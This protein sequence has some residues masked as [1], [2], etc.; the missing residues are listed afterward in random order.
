MIRIEDDEVIGIIHKIRLSD[1]KNTELVEDLLN[2]INGRKLMLKYNI[3]DQERVIFL[4]KS[5]AWK[6]RSYFINNSY[7]F[8]NHKQA[9]YMNDVFFSNVCDFSLYL[10]P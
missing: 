8:D 9:E 6:L 10:I 4:T 1:S 3:D 2:A 7:S 5:V